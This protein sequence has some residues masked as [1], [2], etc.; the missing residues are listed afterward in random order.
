[1]HSLETHSR[2]RFLEG[3][4][5]P[6]IQQEATFWRRELWERAGGTLRTELRYAADFELWMRFFRFTRLFVVDTPLGG[7]RQHGNRKSVLHR[8]DYLA[9]VA[10]VVSEERRR[11]PWGSV[12]ADGVER[13]A[14]RI[15]PGDLSTYLASVGR[16]PTGP[17][18]ELDAERERVIEYLC[19]VN[20][21]LQRENKDLRARLRPFGLVSEAVRRLGA[22]IG[23]RWPRRNA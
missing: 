4:L 22:A 23:F 13:A 18:G 12:P 14:L 1:M 11:W 16:G 19:R 10:R 9:E 15:D 21:A 5:E 8:G 20:D 6:F 2:R 17:E 7:F 3:P